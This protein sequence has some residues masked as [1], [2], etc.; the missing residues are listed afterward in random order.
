M[1][2]EARGNPVQPRGVVGTERI[3][4]DHK[5]GVGRFGPRRKDGQTCGH[6]QRRGATAD[7]CEQRSNRHRRHYRS[8][9]TIF[10]HRRANGC[11]GTRKTDIALAGRVQER[12]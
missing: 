12:W 10:G 3:A 11:I 6:R 7:E 1:A 5:L 9:P 8:R 2:F 4:R